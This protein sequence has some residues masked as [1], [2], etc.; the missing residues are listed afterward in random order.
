[1]NRA[2]KIVLALL[3]V[4]VLYDAY[5][6]VWH[7]SET[8][9]RF[10]APVPEPEPPPSL[11]S[12]EP[13]IPSALK[14]RSDAARNAPSKPAEPA[15]PPPAETEPA[16]EG[17]VEAEREIASAPTKEADR[18]EEKAEAKSKKPQRKP[19]TAP[20]AGR[21]LQA[22]SNGR[23]FAR[24]YAGVR[25]PSASELRRKRLEHEIE[26]AI[27][28]RAIEGVSVSVIGDTVF[29]RGEV[30]TERQKLAAEDVARSVNGVREVRSLI[31]V[32]WQ[33]E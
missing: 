5:E 30:H 29:L 4:A 13:E 22:E 11:R 26:Q 6:I 15:S 27:Q 31:S 14:P 21:K 23:D 20:A 10:P 16:R 17:S 1:M 28:N 3:A 24:N 18:P 7:A 32:G 33:R 2:V 9:S 25:I 19:E 12:L 8:A